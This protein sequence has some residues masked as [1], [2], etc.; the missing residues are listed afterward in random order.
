MT[1]SKKTLSVLGSTGSIG[2]QTLEVAEWKS[3]TVDSIAFGR[4]ISTGEEQ[5]RRFRPRF[6]AVSDEKSAELLKIAV[7]DTSTKVVSGADAINSVLSETRS[8]VCINGIGGFD[9]LLPSISAIR[10]CGRLG[11]ANKETMVAAGKLVRDIAAREGTRLIPVDSEHSTIFRCIGSDP[12]SNVRKLIIT[13]SGGAFYGKTREELKRVTARQALSH[14]TWNMGGMITVNCATLMNK[15][16]EIIEAA[17][18][19]DVGSSRIDVVIHRESIIH[20]LVEYNDRTVKALLSVPDMR[21]PIQYAMEYPDCTGSLCEP[22]DL[23]K[24]G[25]FTFAEPDEKTFP[26][27]ALAKSA[28]EKGG[29]VPCA[30]N[31]AN[32]EA[33]KAFLAEKIGFCNIETVVTSVTENTVSLDAPS[34]DDIIEA[35][36]SAREEALRLINKMQNNIRR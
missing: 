10:C 35:D 7:R 27:L 8:D 32:E 30:M 20:S 33:V 3:F 13:C 26:L 19:F 16:L 28:L 14:P 2:R 29:V 22:L 15:G 24:L 34:L 6:C 17:N 36:R 5:I 9:G 11:L 25:K 4:D 21:V 31:A 1:E 18:L 12:A 23:I